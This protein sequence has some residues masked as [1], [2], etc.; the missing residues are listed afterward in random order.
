MSYYTEQ[1]NKELSISNKA[2]MV[3]YIK[4]YIIRKINDNQNIVKLCRY[5]TK[6]PLFEE[7]ETY[8]GQLIKQEDLE[9]GLLK[10][11]SEE[12]RNDIYIEYP[13]VQS[14]DKILIPYAF[15]N[16]LMT[17]DQLYIFVGNSFAHFSDYY[18]TGEYIFEV[19]ITYD[20]E[21]NMLEPLGEE[22]VIKILEEI[23]KDFDDIYVDNLGSKVLGD[24]K[25][26]IKNFEEIKISK[27]GAMAK[28][29][30]IVAK[31]L[32]NRKLINYA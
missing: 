23:C 12:K 31:P 21:Y 8:N 20:S 6:S 14:R 7:G 28:V 4:Q 10:K 17:K 26:N 2:Q 29:I 5:L 22:R 3:H 11:L 15:N 24:L 32:T 9:C 13:Y 25:F 27:Q 1:Y 30:R 19:V 16:K 18:E